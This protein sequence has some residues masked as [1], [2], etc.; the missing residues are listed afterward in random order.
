MTVN[1]TEASKKVKDHALI[2]L[3]VFSLK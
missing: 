1:S 2:K 3:Q